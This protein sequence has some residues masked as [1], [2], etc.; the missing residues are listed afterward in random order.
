MPVAP[1]GP[2]IMPAVHC[3]VFRKFWSPFFRKFWRSNGST[4]S[5]R[6]GGEADRQDT[7]NGQG[8]MFTEVVEDSTTTL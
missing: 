2:H 8:L 7:A 6:H 5:D 4:R 1:G 3:C